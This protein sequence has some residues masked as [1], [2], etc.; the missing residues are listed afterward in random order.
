MFNIGISAGH[1]EK[2]KGAGISGFYEFDVTLPWAKK[3]CESLSAY[4]DISPVLIPSGTLSSKINFINKFRPKF[5]LVLEIHFNSSPNGKARGSE[6]LYC[7]GSEKGR[8]A[9]DIIQRAMSSVMPPNRGIKEGWYK[10]DR[11]G[12]VDYDGDI[13]GD[14]SINAFLLKTNCTAV[15]IEPEFIQRISVIA[16]QQ[17]ICC[18]VIAKAISDFLFD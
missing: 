3:L 2:A 8:H 6:T 5:Y 18:S 1:Y 7:P 13:D 11:P 12:I 9:A 4:A 10:M 14:E 16:L 17:D 15:I